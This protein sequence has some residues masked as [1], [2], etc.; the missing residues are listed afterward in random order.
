[1]KR[2]IIWKISKQQLRKLINTSLSHAEVLRK[3]GYK[4][5][6]GGNNVNCLK[7]RI[8]I[9][10]INTTHFRQCGRSYGSKKLS[11]KD[12]FVINSTYSRCHLKAR[13]LKYKLLPYKCARCNNKGTWK[14][15]KLILELE[16]KNGVNNDNRLH[17]LEFLCPNC[18]SQKI[19]ILHQHP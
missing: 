2:S 13:I 5:Y 9:E 19:R 8:V 17:N 1:M 7:Q 11:D 3:L 4:Y 12:V 18:H 15:K 14:K 10:H 16:H 6:S